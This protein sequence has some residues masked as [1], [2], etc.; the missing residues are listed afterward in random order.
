MVGLLDDVASRKTM[1]Q[2]HIVFD[3]HDVDMV[4]LQSSAAVCYYHMGW[5]TSAMLV[6]E[7]SWFWSRRAPL[8]LLIAFPQGRVKVVRG[9]E[10]IFWVWCHEE[11]WWQFVRKL[12]L[13]APHR[14][15]S[16]VA[17]VIFRLAMTGC[18]PLS[19]M[20]RKKQWAKLHYTEEWLD[21]WPI[22]TASLWW[23][24]LITLLWVVCMLRHMLK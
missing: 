20:T 21:G 22:V 11:K 17:A 12:F 10:E 23:K 5:V 24:V 8:P 2:K 16:T 4:G 9:V 1:W 14:W 3:S 18:I 6:A 13:C 15:D 7:R 19:P